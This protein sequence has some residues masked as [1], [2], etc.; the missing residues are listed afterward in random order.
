[1]YCVV[2]M[3]DCVCANE[4]VLDDGVYF[5]LHDSLDTIVAI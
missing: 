4:T 2:Y 5:F 3:H 1:M